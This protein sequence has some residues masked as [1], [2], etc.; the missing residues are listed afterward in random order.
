MTLRPRKLMILRGSEAATRE[1]AEAMTRTLAAES[2]A[3]LGPREITQ[4]GQ[5]FDV[6]VLDGHAGLDADR[7]GQAHGLVFG[8]GTLLLLLGDELAPA[9]PRLAVYPYTAAEVGRRFATHVEEVL[10]RH[11]SPAPLAL[12]PA[13]RPS[14]GTL[15]QSR[16][17]A[18]L[19]ERWRAST[20]SRVVLVADRGRG[21]SSAL[22]LALAGLGFG[23][24]IVTAGNEAAAA[25]VLRF[26]GDVVRFVPLLELLSE[27]SKPPRVIV[28]DEA[29]TLPV[30]LLQRLVLAHADAHL[31]FATTTHGYEGTGR[32]FSLRFVAWLAR[33]DPGVERLELH[34]PIRWAPEDPLERAVFEALMLDAEPARLEP[35]ADPSRATIERL[36]RDRLACDRPRL[37]ELFGLLVHAHYRTTPGDLQR[38]LDAPNL[39]IHAALLEGHVVGACVVACEGALPQALIDAAQAGRARLRA[40]ALADVL[41]AHLGHPEAGALRMRR[42]V[43]VAV[44]PSLRRCKLAT[45]LVEHVHAHADVDLFGT[46][47]GA[48]A[49]LIEF[50][51]S[52]GYEVV[53]ISASRGARTGEPAVMML[54][55]ISTPARRLLAELR[56]ELARE[57]DTQLALLQADDGLS[58]EPELIAALRVGLPEV[59]PY[60]PAECLSL[61]RAYAHGPRTFESVATAVRGWLATVELDRLTPELRAVVEG[62]ALALDGWRRVTRDAKTASVSATM[63]A[64]RR[65]IRQ[66]V[67]AKVGVQL[68]TGRLVE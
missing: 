3:W 54:R 9:D 8:G 11:A 17:V 50:R 18:R 44:H 67:D 20:P 25:E 33:R 37:R 53:R 45:R 4:L 38:L 2:I 68:G 63:R 46:L 15:E 41:V 51:R 62:R 47:F 30:P 35:D 22:G 13:D 19:I 16:I 39:E 42:S 31:A 6:V 43:R 23:E 14:A 61:T 34:E 24:H 56:R 32:G 64:L 12:G 65:A 21:K 36:D 59:E 52:L 48:S 7:L 60:S 29:A 26:A 1:Q 40:H 55:P 10:E 58:L 5:A 49:E 28:I 27:S 66:L 57:I